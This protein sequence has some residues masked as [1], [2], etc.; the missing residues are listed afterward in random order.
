MYRTF[1]ITI[2]KPE[3]LIKSGI[4]IVN[5]SKNNVYH[6]IIVNLD[7]SFVK[8]AIHSVKSD[9]ALTIS[10]F[11]YGLGCT[12]L[13]EITFAKNTDKLIIPNDFHDLLELK[14]RLIAKLLLV[15]TTHSKCTNNKRRG[16]IE[17]KVISPLKTKIELV[18]TIILQRKAKFRNTREIF[19][20]KENAVQVNSLLKD[21]AKSKSPYPISGNQEEKMLWIVN[22]WGETLHL[23]HSI[24]LEERSY[25]QQELDLIKSDYNKIRKLAKKREIL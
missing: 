10:E 12:W 24:L 15:R 3:A 5:S 2:D 1:I 25:S 6:E 17:K 19:A 11:L 21:L 8:E 18:S 20:R 13:Y 23:L 9:P 14:K 4:E 16:E 7:H 22:R